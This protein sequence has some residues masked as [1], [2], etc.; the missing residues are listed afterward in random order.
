MK[1]LRVSTEESHA[2]E[3]LSQYPATVTSRLVK[4]S[5]LAIDHLHYDVE[6]QRLSAVVI[7]FAGNLKREEIIK[8]INKISLKV[9]DIPGASSLKAKTKQFLLRATSAMA[10]V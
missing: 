9:E 4:K 3:E 10:K 1:F 7:Q 2:L 5:L 6:T 8:E